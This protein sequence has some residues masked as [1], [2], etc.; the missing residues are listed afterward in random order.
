MTLVALILVVYELDRVG[1][2]KLHRRVLI[3]LYERCIR[4]G[5][6]FVPC[7]SVVDAEVV[8]RGRDGTVFHF[9]FIIDN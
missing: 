8:D 4:P 9:R 2:F 6:E 1:W 7:I 5:L 3:T